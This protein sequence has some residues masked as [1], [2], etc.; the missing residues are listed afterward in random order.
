MPELIS[1]A[2]SPADYQA[3]GTLVADYVVWCRIR[4]RHDE[5]F[6]DRVFGHQDLER[7]LRELRSIYGPPHGCTLLARRGGDICGGGAYRRLADGSCE[8]KRLFVADAFRGLGIGRRLGQALMDAARLEGYTVMRLDTADLLTEA[9]ALY[10]SMG[11]RDCAP[12]RSYP[13]EL[14]PY[15][16]FLE[17]PL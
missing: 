13:A 10:R 6:V 8:M 9:I 14:L 16:V 2:E 11:F 15:L 1:A 12:H 3:F 5:W 7:E 17:L 4:Y